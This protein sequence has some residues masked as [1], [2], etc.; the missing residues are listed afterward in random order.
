VNA[1][2]ASLPYSLLRRAGEYE[3]RRYAAGDLSKGAA[4]AVDGAAVEA[5]RTVAAVG[6]EAGV[7]GDQAR[8]S[9]ATVRKAAERDGLATTPGHYVLRTT[10]GADSKGLVM[11]G[12]E[13]DATC[14]WPLR[15]GNER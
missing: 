15:D 8:I 7:D 10:F 5:P 13:R 4:I 3:V 2:P 14:L 9:A 12:L 6:I 11:V 1:G